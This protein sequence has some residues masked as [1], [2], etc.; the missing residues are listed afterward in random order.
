MVLALQIILIALLVGILVYTA[1]I[2]FSTSRVFKVMTLLIILALTTLACLSPTLV[3]PVA[4]PPSPTAT[5]AMT[6]GIE[7]Q[8]SAA[9]LRETTSGGESQLTDLYNRVNPAVVHIQIYGPGGFSLGSGSG[10]LFD[11]DHHVVTNNHVVQDAED[12]EIVF[13]DGGTG[14]RLASK[15]SDLGWQACQLI[16]IYI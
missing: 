16:L 14:V 4:T 3:T 2:F 7:Q 6:G 13:W 5:P 15:I 12:I 11:N 8:P 1:I 9:P 10:F